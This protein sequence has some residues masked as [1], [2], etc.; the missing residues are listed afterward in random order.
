M[1]RHASRIVVF[2]FLLIGP[3][4]ATLAAELTPVPIQTSAVKLGPE[5]TRIQFVGTHVGPK[6]DPR[7]GGFARFTGAVQVDVAAK[8]VKSVNIE[9]DTGSLWTEFPMLTSHLK[10]ADFFE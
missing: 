10:S 5:N 8:A 2:G 6:P 7:T 4:L 1:T 9:I 3:G